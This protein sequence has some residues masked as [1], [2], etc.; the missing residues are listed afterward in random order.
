MLTFDLTGDKG[1]TTGRFP[2]PTYVQHA[3]DLVGYRKK[4]LKMKLGD[5]CVG[6]FGGV[7]F[8]PHLSSA[9]MHH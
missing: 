5:G 2:C 4:R 3:L 6:G 1:V 7:Q 8:R 9:R